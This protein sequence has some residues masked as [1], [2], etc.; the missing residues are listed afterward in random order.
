V[1]ANLSVGTV[2]WQISDTVPAGSVIS[3]TPGAGAEVTLGTKVYLIVSSGDPTTSANFSADPTSGVAPLSVSFT[4]ESTGNITSWHW[5]FG[6]GAS[7]SSQNPSHTYTDPGTYTVSLT[8]SGPG[9]SDTETKADYIFADMPAIERAALIALYNSTNGDNWSDNGGWDGALGTE[10][11]WYGVTCTGDSVTR[12]SLDY[13]QLTGSIPVELGNL[14]NLIELSLSVNQLTG[15][16][17]SELGNLTNLQRLDLYSN[18]L[19]GSIPSELGN[20]TNLTSL[21]LY[22]NQLSGSI[23]SELGNLT[24][25][26]S[27]DLQ[28]N[29]LS[30]EIPKELMNLDPLFYLNICDNH[31]YSTYPDLRDF[32]NETHDDDWENCQDLSFTRAM[33]WN[34]LL[35]LDE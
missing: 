30:G 35:L 29:E 23:P 3:Q 33:P 11:S 27:L 5:S 28:K 19:S 6:D 32:L 9:G 22:S 17:P 4:D 2:T 15:S 31:L 10:C 14:T 34:Q 8:V 25:L 1:A 21:N 20:L 16:I 24:A 12:L 7:S 13:N 18:Q 26:T